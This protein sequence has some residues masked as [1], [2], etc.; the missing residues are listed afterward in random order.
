MSPK[1]NLQQLKDGKVVVLREI[2]TKF[3]QD[4]YAKL[5]HSIESI[6][7]GVTRVHQKLYISRPDD[8]FFIDDLIYHEFDPILSMIYKCFRYYLLLYIVYLDYLQVHGRF[9]GKW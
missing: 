6:L 7:R 4:L 8:V 9:G 2:V 1:K 3:E 5:Q